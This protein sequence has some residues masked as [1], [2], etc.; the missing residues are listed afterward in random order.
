MG[1]EIKQIFKRKRE[2]ETHQLIDLYNE[3]DH[4]DHKSNATDEPN[5][6]EMFEEIEQ[7]I[8]AYE[9]IIYKVIRRYE[10]VVSKLRIEKNKNKF[11]EKKLLTFVRKDKSDRTLYMDS[12]LNEMKRDREARTNLYLP[13]EENHEDTH[14]F[15]NTTIEGNTPTLMTH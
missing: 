15:A 2:T 8:E 14:Q 9:K 6:E 4:T 3:E 13:T 12:K 10:V 1:Y 5:E 7:R 11:L